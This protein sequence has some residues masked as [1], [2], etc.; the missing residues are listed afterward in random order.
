MD[1]VDLVIDIVRNAD[2]TALARERLQTELPELSTTAQLDAVL[3]LQLGQLTKLNGNRLKEERKTLDEGIANLNTLL[4]VDDAVWKEMTDEFEQIAKK[5]GVPRR[6]TIDTNEDVNGSK[7]LTDMDLITNSRSVIVVTRSGYIKRLPLQTFSNQGR[8]TRG[9]KST[10]TSSSSIN[11]GHDDTTVSHCFTCNDHDTLLI[12]TQRGVAFGLRAF[13]IP[14]ASR[15]A[16]GVP[17]PSVLPFQTDDVIAS[18]LPVSTF[19]NPN[20][21]C[22]LATEKGWI[23]KTPLGA[24]ENLTSRGL[25]IATLEEGDRLRWFEK[26]TDDN[27]VLI[28]SRRGMAT[29]FVAAKLRPTGRTSR[30]VRSMKLKDGDTLADMSILTTRSS[31][32]G[33]NGSATEEAEQFVLVV[34]KNGYGKRV[35]TKEF[36]STARGGVGV[37]SI[38]FKKSK[39]DTDGSDIASCLRVVKEDDEVLLT[40]TKGIIV[41]QRVGDIP[42]QGRT[43]TG[44]TVQKIDSAGGDAISSVSIIPKMMEVEE[45]EITS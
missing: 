19:D 23:K 38:K 42:S 16:R 43:A 45:E 40:T 22:V 3:R 7:D 2:T 12:T 21:Y 13:R 30:G 37:I 41:R 8:G 25:I 20:E 32:E 5:Y 1:H 31:G 33:D 9:K 39:D 17:I 24:F 6:T 15:T 36:R 14:I 27:D 18:I 4:T 10:S 26:C 34:T 44:V 11:N 35:P 28:G 29:R